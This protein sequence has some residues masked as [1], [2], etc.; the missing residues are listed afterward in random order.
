MTTIVFIYAVLPKCRA[1][2]SAFEYLCRIVGC[3]YL[4]L[5]RSGIVTERNAAH[6]RP[7]WP[8]SLRLSCAN[9]PLP[10]DY[11]APLGV[12]RKRQ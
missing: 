11:L 7:M 12:V 6:F 3:G 10:D 1:H 9:L 8:F 4:E 2:P 5:G